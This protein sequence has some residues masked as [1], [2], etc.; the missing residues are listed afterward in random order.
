MQDD[1]TALILAAHYGHLQ[2]VQELLKRDT[3]TDAQDK[4]MQENG[5]GAG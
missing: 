2:I 1:N 5:G 4:V 3:H